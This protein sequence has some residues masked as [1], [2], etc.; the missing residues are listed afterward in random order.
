[1]TRNCFVAPR[2][3]SALA[4]LAPTTHAPRGDPSFTSHARTSPST[5]THIPTTGSSRSGSSAR[6]HHSALAGFGPLDANTR[7]AGDASA[8]RVNSKIGTTYTPPALVQHNKLSPSRECAIAWILARD[9]S[10]HGANRF[11]ARRLAA[12]KFSTLAARALPLAPNPLTEHANARPRASA[13]PSSPRA[14]PRALDAAMNSI[15]PSS[16]S[17]L[18][19][20]SAPALAPPSV[21]AYPNMALMLNDRS[22]APSG[23]R[24]RA[25]RRRSTP[26]ASSTTKISHSNRASASVDAPDASRASRAR[27]SRRS[28]RVSRASASMTRDAAPSRRRVRIHHWRANPLHRTSRCATRSIASRRTRWWF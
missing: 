24:A 15:A 19:A 27:A 28:A 10:Y 26:S 8:S 4:H 6:Y 12:I 3:S 11:V 23:G 20:A 13:S 18:A 7:I 5:P 25:R 16:N 2:A 21:C 14:R 22:T 1:M 9:P 17:S